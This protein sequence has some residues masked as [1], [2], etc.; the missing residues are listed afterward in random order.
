MIT[1][2]GYTKISKSAK[3]IEGQAINEL[4]TNGYKVWTGMPI[5]KRPVWLGSL[6]TS[7]EA[8][9]EKEFE[10]EVMRV[11]D[12]IWDYIGDSVDY[13]VLEKSKQ[14]QVKPYQRKGKYVVGHNRLDPRE[15]K[16]GFIWDKLLGWLPQESSSS[17]KTKYSEEF[18]SEVNSKDF[19]DWFGGSKTI[20]VG[21]QFSKDKPKLYYHRS[22]ED[23]RR[24]RKISD[25]PDYRDTGEEGF[26]FSEKPGDELFLKIRHPYRTREDISSISLKRMKELREQGYDGIEGIGETV[27]FKP[28]Q[29]RMFTKNG[30]LL[31]LGEP[32]VSRL[33]DEEFKEEEAKPERREFQSRGSEGRR[34]YRSARSARSTI[35]RIGK[36]FYEVT[37][38]VVLEKAGM[39]GTPSMPGMP[40][41]PGLVAVK[42]TVNG[43]SGPYQA[44]RWETPEDA[45]RMIKEGKA[46]GMQS[47]Q[48]GAQQP[49][50][51]KPS[52]AVGEKIE[53]D[54]ISLE[55]TAVG[56]D[57]VTARDEQGQR[58]QITHQNVQKEEAKPKEGEEK[59]KEVKAKE[60]KPEVKSKEAEPPA[61]KDQELSNDEI[62]ELL[63]MGA[64]EEDMVVFKEH[65]NL[66]RHT[67][68]RN[69]PKEEHPGRNIIRNAKKAASDLADSL[70]AISSKDGFKASIKIESQRGESV[71]SE[72]KFEMGGKEAGIFNYTVNNNGSVHMSEFF[73]HGFA[74]GKGL[75]GDIV[76]GIVKKLDKTNG[77]ISLVANGDVGRYAWA[78]MGFDFADK[79]LAQNMF[80]EFRDYLTS[81]G[82]N[83]KE[84]KFE[85]SWDIATFVHK[86]EKLGKDFLLHG[87]ARNYYAE[88]P[89]NPDSQGYKVF[90]NFM[91]KRRK[92]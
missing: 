6:K 5:R 38:Y 58:H 37:N 19:K 80:S 86:G 20:E 50:P 36:S 69:V 3:N 61:N 63:R 47:Q 74:T 57:G 21:G 44:I 30:V 92:I 85:H 79:D 42:V 87:G 75:G 81:K 29:I 88:L 17:K 43:P 9:K 13:V 41:R 46:F 39:P 71:R 66:G 53:G 11:S 62:N 16:A 26:Y 91:S 60:A 51:P 23:F 25:K 59:P 64:K 1:V 78:I 48:Q 70:K 56:R 52:V 49:E 45:Q 83:P 68:L 8:K 76:E 24:F 31:K 32:K 90:G 22:N 18:E 28:S 12:T 77:K 15:K 54:G 2:K 72:I 35:H 55:V 73:M 65:P 27:V 67:L 10:D 89:T 33:S 40:P 82:V 7:Q 14:V 84:L 34:K 4:E